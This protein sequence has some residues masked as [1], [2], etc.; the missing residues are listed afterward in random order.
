MA[1]FTSED[2]TW[3]FL[4]IEEGKRQ[5]RGEPA[6]GVS[7]TPAPSARALEWPID[8]D[9]RGL[10][11]LGLVLLRAFDRGATPRE[12]ERRA[13]LLAAK[14]AR[15]QRLRDAEA[16]ARERAFLATRQANLRAAAQARRRAFWTRLREVSRRAFASGPGPAR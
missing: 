14:E 13:R 16:L 3:Y 12:R 10:D 4:G 8:D 2:M 1:G 5:S 11:G 6:R 7:P 15:R 9:L